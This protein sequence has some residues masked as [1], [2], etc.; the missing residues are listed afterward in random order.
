MEISRAT[1]KSDKFV[2]NILRGWLGGREYVNR[3]DQASL[4]NS[5]VSWV[6]VCASRNAAAFATL[7]PLR[8]YAVKQSSSQKLYSQHRRVT[9]AQ[10]KWLTETN[11]VTANS[12][13][14]K[15]AV[16]LVEVTSHRAI[17]L[18][19]N[20]NPLTTNV[21][22]LEGTELFQELT[23]NEYWYLRKDG[24][25]NV[26]A[27]IWMMSPDRV[28]AIPGTDT[29][30]A[31]WEYV[32]GYGQKQ[33]FALDE[34]IHFK[35]PNPH[36]PVY[37]ASP[38]MAVCD[39]FNINQN[40]NRYENALFTNN[41]RPEGFFTTAEV[42]DDAT[43]SRLKNE[44][45]DVYT[46]VINAGKSALLDGGVDWKSAGLPPRDLAF[47]QGRRWTQAEI[48][49]AFDTPMGMFDEKANRA[50]AEAAQY[51]YSKYC[52]YPRHRR[53][54][55]TLNAQLMPM[56]DENLIFAFDN[57]IIED[58]DF[59]L[60][61]DTELL[62]AFTLAPNEV[63]KKRGYEP[64]EGGDELYVPGGFQPIGLVSQGG[65]LRPSGQPKPGESGDADDDGKSFVDAVSSRV[66]AQILG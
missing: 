64:K 13:A 12:P 20:I 7:A 16:E 57:S 36:D 33:P 59:E 1:V 66:V 27:Q 15:S 51:T 19:R 40:M 3:E 26:P 56:F 29:P 45:D 18:L 31:S 24:V 6:Y 49:E 25:F 54:E 22:L 2:R 14:L 4:L 53:F 43:W 65:T 9:R 30:V 46:G 21:G 47:L 42:L 44:L 63:R 11:T 38:L 61:Q 58:K 35:F 55:A 34:I 41:A 60:R 62:K 50:N 32:T 48:F 37:G 28:V 10:E 17:D 8:L 23:G 5:Y 39:A 52:I